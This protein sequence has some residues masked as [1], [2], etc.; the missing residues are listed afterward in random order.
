MNMMMLL[1]S[2]TCY[3]T[4]KETQWF[5]FFRS[6]IMHSNKKAIFKKTG[7]KNQGKMNQLKFFQQFF[8]NVQSANHLLTCKPYVNISTNGLKISKSSDVLKCCIKNRTKHNLLMLQCRL[9]AH[10]PLKNRQHCSI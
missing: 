3:H 1:C 2:Q 6:L 10:K 4:G 9:R 7:E 5:F 8:Y